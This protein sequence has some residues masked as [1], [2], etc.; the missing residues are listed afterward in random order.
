MAECC[1][2]S[3]STP[4][5]FFTASTYFV[6]CVGAAHIS[7]APFSCSY[8]NYSPNT[9][10]P[11]L[12]SYPE[13]KTDRLYSYIQF[14]IQYASIALLYYDYS[15][16]FTQ[17]VEYVWKSTFRLS[18]I[19]YM[20]CRYA[21]VANVVYLLNIS[22]KLNIQVSFFSCD[23]GYKVCSALSVLGR[24]AIIIV[25]TARAYAV[26]DRSL[27]ILFSLGTSGLACLILSIVR[28]ILSLQ[29]MNK[30]K[31]S[32]LIQIF[33]CV[34]EFISAL[35]A[36]FRCMQA[37]QI[38]GFRRNHGNRFLYLICDQ[39]SHTVFLVSPVKV[40]AILLNRGGFIQRL[41]NALTLPISGLLT[42]RFLLCLRMWEDNAS[43]RHRR[44]R[45]SDLQFTTILQSNID[46]FGGDPIIFEERNCRD[47]PLR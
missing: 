26:F 5:Q 14:S 28:S 29:I 27:I 15:L 45:S 44:N 35:L 36:T 3:H 43:K 24:T 17:E 12:K 31:V 16:T 23:Y 6:L 33:M 20:F 10:C 39:G 38:G 42:A 40:L 47:D 11:N 21:L 22:N 30:S 25:W 7:G 34:F 13:K 19:L 46:E 2:A 8:D 4:P 37:I 18:T 1:E 32:L 9:V 41:L